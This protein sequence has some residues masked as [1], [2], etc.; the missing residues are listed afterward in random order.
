MK[1][2]QKHNIYDIH[3]FLDN[4]KSFYYEEIFPYISKLKKINNKE[5]MCF[6]YIVGFL[7]QYLFICDD[8]KKILVDD[9]INLNVLS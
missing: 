5:N 2:D 4:F 7:P 6:Y 3:T 1:S 8:N 9:V